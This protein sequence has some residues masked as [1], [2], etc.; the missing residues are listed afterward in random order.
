MIKL[1]VFDFG[2]VY[3]SYN[4]PKLRN[5]LSRELNVSYEEIVDAW[6]SRLDDFERGKCIEKEF[7]K[8]FLKK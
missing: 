5:E 2:G 7:W 3:F 4:G 6:Y 1:I 8:A